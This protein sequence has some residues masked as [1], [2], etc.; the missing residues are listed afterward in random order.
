[1]INT[2]KTS[3]RK[4]ETISLPVSSPGTKRTLDIIHYGNPGQG[5]KAYLQAALHADEIPGLLLIHK[6]IQLLDEA[7]QAGKILGYIVLAPIANPIGLSQHLFAE[8][9]GR[10]DQSSGINFNRNYPELADEI[11]SRIA[12][13]LSNDAQA[14]TRLIRETAKTIID[15][16]TPQNETAFL[17]Q[18]LMRNAVDADIVLDLHCDWQSVMHFYTGTPLWPALEDLAA[19]MQAKAVLLEQDS[20]GNPFDEAV[21]GLWWTL[22]KK[23]PDRPID[24]ACVAA[25]I[26]L[27]G[28]ADTQEL[29][30]ENDAQG[31]FYYLQSRGLIKGK[32]PVV[33]KL[34][35]AATPLDGVEKI[36]AP[37]AAVVSYQKK[38]GDY[39]NPGD[40]V[41]VLFD[42]TE[43]EPEK[44][45][46]ELKA[47][48]AG[49]LYSRR[50]DRLARPGQV[51]ARIAGA[52]SLA[53]QAG[54]LLDD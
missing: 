23:F 32:P 35:M 34:E 1:M 6:L 47:T 28:K 48:V 3:S 14:N 52:D 40:V 53:D 41:C 38:P 26:E 37:I 39:I 45:R 50:L 21:S 17:K 27:R 36:T 8:L 2:T 33:P 42:I 16:Q 13:E 24:N 12:D 29:Q 54:L 43:Y 10:Y 9:A 20:G 11:A 31:L 4:L 18:L 22:A 7:D 15:E 46:I 19:Y 49:V 25:T 5:P 30:A 51:L 44:A